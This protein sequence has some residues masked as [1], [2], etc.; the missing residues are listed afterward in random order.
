MKKR[1]ISVIVTLLFLGVLI[2]MVVHTSPKNSSTKSG[3]TPADLVSADESNSGH[4]YNKKGFADNYITYSIEDSSC[5]I[6]S[7]YDTYLLGEPSKTDT[8]VSYWSVEVGGPTF[9]APELI[10]VSNKYLIFS[11]KDSSNTD[12]RIDIAVE[13]E[14]TQGGYL[15]NYFHKAFLLDELSDEEKSN[16]HAV[17]MLEN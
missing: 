5:V 6:Y 4:T 14:E 9:R 12:E 15:N 10:G 2:A 13:I 3:I 8:G 11:V 1:N 17:H 16:I 7:F